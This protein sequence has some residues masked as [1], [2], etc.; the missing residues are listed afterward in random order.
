VRTK[1]LTVTITLFCLTY[2]RR[3]FTRG[4]LQWKPAKHV[5]AK[6]KA[7]KTAK[8]QQGNQWTKYQR[9]DGNRGSQK[10]LWRCA[11]LVQQARN[12]IFQQSAI[13][14]KGTR[15][16]GWHNLD[17]Q[18]SSINKRKFLSVPKLTSGKKC[19][20]PAC[21]CDIPWLFLASLF[22]TLFGVAILPLTNSAHEVAFVP[23]AHALWPGAM[24]LF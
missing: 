9:N 14:V 21:S 7:N 15:H 3:H 4:R 1:I 19:N 11:Y 2:G 13:V 23:T 8:R 12:S 10:F 16:P 18:R 20:V 22:A 17:T 24:L 6:G 5:Q